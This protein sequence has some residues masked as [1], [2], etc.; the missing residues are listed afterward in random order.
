MEVSI[1]ESIAAFRAA[2]AARKGISLKL[3]RHVDDDVSY[4]DDIDLSESP[5]NKSCCVGQIMSKSNNSCHHLSPLYND[6]FCKTSSDFADEIEPLCKRCDPQSIKVWKQRKKR[7][8]ILL[9]EVLGGTGPLASREMKLLL[10]PSA[11]EKKNL[12]A[13][14][15]SANPKDEYS[16]VIIARWVKPIRGMGG[17]PLQRVCAEYKR[18]ISDAADEINT[19]WRTENCGKIMSSRRGST[20]D[21]HHPRSRSTKMP[22]QAAWTP[23]LGDQVS[24]SCI[25]SL[26]N[27]S[28]EFTIY[29]FYRC[30]YLP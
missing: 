9:R 29:F 12:G 17:G 18:N 1:Q 27:L 30:R 19:N 21:S 13:I 16:G 7:F 15:S 5:S 14:L 23:G 3:F 2:V 8:S 25:Y 10:R 11:L 6:G 26:L 28:L 20:A 4:I 22:Q 24:Y